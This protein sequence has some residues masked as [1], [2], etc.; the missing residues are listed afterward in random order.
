MV[1]RK[2]S[3]KLLGQVSG[4]LSLKYKR[5]MYSE[6][7]LSPSMNFADKSFQDFQIISPLNFRRTLTPKI[8]KTNLNSNI[9]EVGGIGVVK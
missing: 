3:D 6:L 4:F 8:I 7:M 2:W 5:L 9:C 1:F